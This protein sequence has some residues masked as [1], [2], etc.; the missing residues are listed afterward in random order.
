MQNR[1]V[2]VLA[3]TLRKLLS[4]NALENIQNLLHKCHEADIAFV[5]E[6]LDLENQVL[7][8][9]QIDSREKK[10]LCLAELP[11]EK[12]VALL[13]KVGGE[14]G[15]EILTDVSPDDR[16]DILEA[17]PEDFSAEVLSFLKKD[18]VKEVEDLIQY[19]PDTAGG[20]MSP[21]F[22]A[23]P[24]EA[25]VEA[26]IRKIQ[27]ARDA[28]TLFYLYVVNPQGQLVG[29]V[30]LKKLILAPPSRPLKEIMDKDPIRVRLNEDQEE[31][32]QIVARYNFLSVPVV[33]GANRLVG[34]ITVDDVIDV[35]KEE[36][37]E[38]MLLMAGAD[39]DAL[40]SSTLWE[41]LKK[42][43][44]WFALTLIG[45]VAASEIVLVYFKSDWRLGL[46]AGFIPLVLTMGSAMGTQTMTVV[47]SK[48][49][50]GR[51]T[52]SSVWGVLRKEFVLGL[53]IGLFYALL[54]SLF[55]YLRHGSDFGLPGGFAAA[56]LAATWIAAA[57][58]CLVPFLFR[59]MG[60]DPAVIT[61]PLVTTLISILSVWVYLSLASM[62]LFRA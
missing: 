46:L 18:E 56:F 39:K 35:I 7:L 48:V 31:V 37:K 51:F 44:P 41:G 43:I 4:C 10:A 38:D 19:A 45:G 5:L 57:L 33:D 13:E 17:L 9:G 14:K 27:E 59:R 26:T 40:E 21:E 11:L 47:F 22:F 52:W 58:G 2:Q 53:V 55:F 54:L 25:T 50:G 15:A 1:K 30:S 61:T 28:E 20:I 60:I 29:V 24:E 8:L 32:A 62:F 16:A 42:R 49:S 3:E 12:A 23:M 6:S 34:L 36:A